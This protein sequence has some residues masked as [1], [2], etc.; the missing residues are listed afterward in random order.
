MKIVILPLAKGEGMYSKD[1]FTL[2]KLW[3]LFSPISRDKSV[4]PAF[5]P[6][7]LVPVVRQ[8]TEEFR[9]DVL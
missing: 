7:M 2:T 5:L 3:R 9:T 1:H 4:I 8:V 6:G